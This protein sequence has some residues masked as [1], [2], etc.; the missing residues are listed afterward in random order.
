M[1]K[2]IHF[3]IVA[4]SICVAILT[5][6]FIANIIAKMLILTTC[7]F[8]LCYGAAILEVI[9]EDER[10]AKRRKSFTKERRQ[11]INA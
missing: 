8:S 2:N 5:L 4:L 3:I 1:K 9:K 10:I 11:H 6:V 7:L